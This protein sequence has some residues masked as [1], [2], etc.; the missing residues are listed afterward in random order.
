[1]DP[2][3]GIYGIYTE[4]IPNAVIF[5]IIINH[6]KVMASHGTVYKQVIVNWGKIN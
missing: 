1:M 2:S 3:I 4:K 6:G 5:T